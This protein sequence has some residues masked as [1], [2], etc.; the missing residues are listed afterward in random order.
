MNLGKSLKLPLVLGVFNLY[1]SFQCNKKP[2][3][4]TFLRD[5]CLENVPEVTG[6]QLKTLAQGLR[7][8]DKSQKNLSKGVRGYWQLLKLHIY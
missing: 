7:S 3:P 6:K 5:N 1:F 2:S 8:T 4:L